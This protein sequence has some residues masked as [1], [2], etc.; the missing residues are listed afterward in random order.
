ML[1]VIATYLMILSGAFIGNNAGIVPYNAFVEGALD[2]FKMK[3]LI[4]SLTKAYTFAFMISS[5][6]C[7]Q[8]YYSSGGATGVG[9][10]STKAVVW[11]CVLI[12]FSDYLI[13]QL[14]L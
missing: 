7:Y 14:F 2:I 8:G 4:L 12:L 9:R 6:S 5:I 3:V 13:A 11:S 1:V 10:S